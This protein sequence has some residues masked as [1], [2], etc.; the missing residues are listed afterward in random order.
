M[1]T[2]DSAITSQRASS[3]LELDND[4]NFIPYN[5]RPLDA[6]RVTMAHEFFHAIHFGMDYTEY[7]GT[8]SDARLYWWEMSATWMEEMAYDGIN[9]YYGYLPGFYDF[10]WVSLTDFTVGFSMHPYGSAVFPIFLTEKWDTSLVQNIWFRCR[11]Y[12]TGAQFLRAADDAIFHFDSLLKAD[13][14]AADSSYIDSVY[15]LRHAFHEFAIWNL[16]TGNRASRAPAGIGFSEG[17]NYSMIDDSA[18]VFLDE[19]PINM[20]WPNWRDIFPYYAARVPQNLAANYINLT[21]VSLFDSLEFAFYGARNISIELGWDL[22]L[23]AFP[24]NPLEPAII[25]TSSQGIESGHIED[26]WYTRNYYNIVAIP[27]AVSIY[28]SAYP[29][30]FGYSY[31]VLDTP[32]MDI[33]QYVIMAPYPNPVIVSSGNDKVSFRLA[34]PLLRQQESYFK[35]YIYDIAGEKIRELDLIREE[36]NLLILEWNLENHRKEKVAPGVYLAL[37]RATFSDNTPELIKKYKLAIIK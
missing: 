33:S 9:D 13:Q 19:Y 10:P 31:F 34:R 21:A 17:G 7:E 4:Y 16:F 23:V 24:F 8:P 15:H 36:Q 35:V 29:G 26:L 14:I 11:D 30:S 37:C 3:Y 5:T 12:G 22:S 32:S 27:T 28:N 20:P 25:K 6:V 2:G 1:T 18:F